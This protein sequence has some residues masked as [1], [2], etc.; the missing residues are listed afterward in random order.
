M[1]EIYQKLKEYIDSQ[2]E[3]MCELYRR[4]VNIDSGSRNAQGVNQVCAILREAMEASGV[5]TRIIEQ[6]NVGNI[7]IGEWNFE[8]NDKKPLVILGHMDTV[9]PDGTAASNPFRIDE[10]GLV[11]GPGC[12]DMKPGLIMG[13]YTMKALR[14][15]G[16]DSRPIKFIYVCDEENLH[17]FSKTPEII[18]EEV[19]GALAA[20]NYETGYMDDRMVVGRKGGGIIEVVVHGV[21][22][23]SGIAPEKG[24]SA[25][26]EAAHKMIEI[27]SQTDIPAGRLMNCGLIQGGIGENTVP[28]T[29]SFRIGIRFPSVKIRDEILDIIRRAAAHSTVPD[30]TADVNI[31]MLMDSM[32][33]TD[34]VNALFEHIRRTAADCGYGEVGSFVVSG[35]SDSGATVSAGIPTV[36]AMGPKGEGNHTPNE[37]AVLESFYQRTWLAACAAYTLQDDFAG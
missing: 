2:R 21:A 1:Q 6:E 20:F 35:V 13:L 7:L 36:C 31:R 29:C 25:I 15:V 27:E 16:Y 4:I 19:K 32:D 22:A 11:H 8:R 34:G 12:L 14:E 17:M 5:H 3:P 18:K 9:F 23:H 30:T 24:R 37:Y 10:E 33:N 28:D 26:I